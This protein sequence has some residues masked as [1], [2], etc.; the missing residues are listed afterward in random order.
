MV[1]A[2]IELVYFLLVVLVVLDMEEQ[3]YNSVQPAG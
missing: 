1:H 2:N 3:S